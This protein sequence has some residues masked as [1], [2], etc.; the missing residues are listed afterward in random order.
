MAKGGT[1]KDF[2][3][4]VGLIRIT[5]DSQLRKN[6]ISLLLST[7]NRNMCQPIID[8]ILREDTFVLEYTKVLNHYES[9]DI[10][11]YLVGRLQSQ[12]DA[13]L[14]GAFWVLE[15]SI[16]D[17]ESLVVLWSAAD[18]MPRNESITRS[19]QDREQDIKAT[20]YATIANAF[21]TANYTT[22]F[23][24]IAANQFT[25]SEIVAIKIAYGNLRQPTD[26]SWHELDE[27]YHANQPLHKTR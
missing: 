7:Q 14:H 10:I 18:R 3:A 24:R 12:Q 25:P 2:T 19:G 23:D 17:A 9:R 13:N 22:I 20:Y 11:P 6:L 8:D 15:H 26:L 21:T 4:I 27:L 16:P 5:K 1:K